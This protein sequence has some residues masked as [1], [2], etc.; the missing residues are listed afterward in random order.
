MLSHPSLEQAGSTLQGYF[1]INT[2]PKK[3]AETCLWFKVF[4][5]INIRDVL[6]PDSKCKK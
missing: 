1:H 3:H 4:L 6:T 5:K 2:A